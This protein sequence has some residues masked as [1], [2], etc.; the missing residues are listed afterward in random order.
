MKR[1]D[2]GDAV[3]AREIERPI[4]GIG[5]FEGDIGKLGGAGAGETDH[6]GGEVEGED[7]RTR[8]RRD[9]CGPRVVIAVPWAAEMLG[10]SSGEGAGTAADLKHAVTIGW[11]MLQEVMVIVIVVGC[12]I[13]RGFG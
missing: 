4:A 3:E 8:G 6:F 1:G 5:E 10:Q 2:V 9:A 11:E 13:R 12:A 7:L